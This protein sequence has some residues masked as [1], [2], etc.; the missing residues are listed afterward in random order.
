MAESILEFRAMHFPSLEIKMS[1]S[2]F[3]I[4][5]PRSEWKIDVVA[6]GR[7]AEVEYFEHYINRLYQMKVYANRAN[8]S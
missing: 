3:N 1:D 6:I 4:Y 2:K 7:E 8:N 5:V